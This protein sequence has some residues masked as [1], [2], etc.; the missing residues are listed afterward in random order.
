MKISIKNLNFF[1]LSVLSFITLFDQVLSKK[2]D[3]NAVPITIQQ[4]Y[5]NTDV[6]RFIDLTCA[7]IVRSKINLKIKKSSTNSGKENFPY[8]FALPSELSELKLASFQVFLSKQSF[9]DKNQ[10]N[11]VVEKD[12]I[13]AK[14]GVQYFKLTF[15]DNFKVEDSF[16]KVKIAFTNLLKP[17]PKSVEQIPK[18]SQTG[19]RQLL[20]FNGF[21]HFWSPYLTENQKTTI[22]LPK[23]HIESYTASPKPVTKTDK[24]LTYGPYR[25]VS[26]ITSP[27]STDRIKIHFEHPHAILVAKTH[28]RIVEVSHWSGKLGVEDHI[29]LHHNGAKIKGH[30]SNIDYRLTQ[31]MQVDTNVV[32]SIPLV[33]PAN[34]VDVYFK[35]TIGNVSTTN[36]RNEKK[37]SLLEFRPRY[38]LYGGWKYSWFYGYSVPISQFL[39]SNKNKYEISVDFYDSM[40][41]ITVE[42]A[43]L[44]IS[45]PEGS[46]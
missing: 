12:A 43:I 13:D 24:A 19:S 27:E 38:P 17:F 20:L 5:I 44:K 25:D 16:L 46:T 2:K 22:R 14:S 42:K 37:R 9:D 15:P 1:L 31:H 30:Y 33:L 4:H 3:L 23:S 26:A 7:S 41:N 35:D 40:H 34:A 39:K 6:Q 18:T 36:F 10:V 28:E 45:L 29:D 32:K 21:A 8:Y 11:T